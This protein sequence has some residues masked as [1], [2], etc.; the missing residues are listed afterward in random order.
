MMDRPTNR[1]EG[2][3]VRARVM[4]HVHDMS[5]EYALQMYEAS[6]KYL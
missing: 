2:E 5:S 1:C 4:V 6:M 3:N